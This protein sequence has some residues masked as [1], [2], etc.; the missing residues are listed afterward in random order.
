[1]FE[2]ERFTLKNA[3]IDFPVLR[4]VPVYIAG[5]GP[6]VLELAGEVADGV[7]IGG[8]ASAAGIGYAQNQIQ[9]G[10]DK[11][12]RTSD[13]VDRMSWVY[14]SVADDPRAA[15]VA[16]S[17]IVLASLI[18]SRPIIDRLGLTIPPALMAH[19]EATE[20]RYPTIS[21]E[22]SNALLPDE[23]ID[24]FAIYGT[25]AQVRK[26]LADI[27]ACGIDHVTFV[28][29]PEAGTDHEQLA[30]RIAREVV[31]PSAPISL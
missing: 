29:F 6:K 1:M 16:V 3:G 8:F 7:I 14:T 31:A 11:A 25:P 10:I 23:I 22:E 20:W 26:R 5:R 28:L 18:T 17:R 9:F 30:A 24:A 19:L 27:R 4:Q 15:R 2:G 12:G 13:D 21:P